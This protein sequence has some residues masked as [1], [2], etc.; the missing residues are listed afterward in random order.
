M[1]DYSNLLF[2][3]NDREKFID[4]IKELMGLTVM[5]IAT[6]DVSTVESS[7]AIEDV[8][9]IFSEKGMKK[10]PVVEQGRLVGSISRSD[11]IRHTMTTMEVVSAEAS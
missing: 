5:Q 9:R 1:F 4:R 2:Q 3:Y 11:I 6:T 7:V 10:L 8:A